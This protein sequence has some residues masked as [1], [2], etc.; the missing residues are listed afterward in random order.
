MRPVS[1]TAQSM[2]C[3]RSSSVLGLA[4]LYKSAVCEHSLM[5]DAVPVPCHV[6]LTVICS[7]VDDYMSNDLCRAHNRND[8][9]TPA[10]YVADCTHISISPTETKLRH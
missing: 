10:P 8:S 7:G 4:S 6:L 2:T 1:S 3:I 5:N 9:V